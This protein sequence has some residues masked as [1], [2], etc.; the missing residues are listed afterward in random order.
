[1]TST[2]KRYPYAK[3]R[4]YGSA[5]IA[6]LSMLLAALM[7]Q[8]DPALAFYYLLYST[9]ST[10]VF[11]VATFELKKRLYPLLVDSSSME[12]DSKNELGTWKRLLLVFSML[13][14]SITVPLLLALALGGAAWF[15]LMISFILGVSLSEIV[16][17][18]IAR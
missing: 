14:A 9:L 8:S 13:I 5:I 17:Y 12:D 3:N 11:T 4:V 15:I 10:A 18:L 7:F 1:M 6:A 16:F 2:K